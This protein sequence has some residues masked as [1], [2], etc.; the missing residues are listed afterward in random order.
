MKQNINEELKRSFRPEFLN[1]IDDIIVFHRLD[2]NDTRAI[3][4]LMLDVVAKR[5]KERGITLSYTD[6]AADKLADN[7]FDREYGAR[8]LRRLI[9]QTVE[10]NLSEQILEGNIKLS[11]T[12]EMYLDEKGEFAFR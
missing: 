9:Q 10:D 7:G 3:S 2:E 4:R 1:R 11:D 6:E 8:P 5:L 12:V